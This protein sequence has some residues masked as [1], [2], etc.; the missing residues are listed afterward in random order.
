[1]GT[2]LVS[3]VEGGRPSVRP[4]KRDLCRR[5]MVAREEQI[6]ERKMGNGRTRVERDWSGKTVR[7]CA[8]SGIVLGYGSELGAHVRRRIWAGWVAKRGERSVIT[9]DL[10]PIEGEWAIRHDSGGEFGMGRAEMGRPA[11]AANSRAPR[12][13]GQSGR[14]ADAG[15]GGRV[16]R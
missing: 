8:F 3:G 1:M 15:G 2:E 14:G 10:R 5:M 13:G 6:W 4:E 7:A 9:G 12:G 16:D 11:A